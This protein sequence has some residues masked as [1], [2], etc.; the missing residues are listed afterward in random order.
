M[1]GMNVPFD[2]IASKK[3]MELGLKVKIL[4]MNTEN[5]SKCLKGKKFVGTVIG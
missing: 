4:N 5:I 3:A 1:P 2:P